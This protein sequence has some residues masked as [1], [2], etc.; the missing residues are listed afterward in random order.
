MQYM[1]APSAS[2]ARNREYLPVNSSVDTTYEESL[3]SECF[4]PSEGTS[5]GLLIREGSRA[6]TSIS[7]C[8]F[9]SP[10]LPLLEY[11]PVVSAKEDSPF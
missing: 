7:F 2:S 3:L 1:S 4:V 5:L 8:P 11:R 6:F 10:C 9:A